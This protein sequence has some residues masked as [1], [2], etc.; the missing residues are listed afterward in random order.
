MSYNK[1]KKL[2][3]VIFK[4]TGKEKE[5]NDRIENLNHGVNVEIDPLLSNFLSIYY[6]FSV[7]RKDYSRTP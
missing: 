6:I 5:E 2:I 7:R 3:K 1:K 4:P